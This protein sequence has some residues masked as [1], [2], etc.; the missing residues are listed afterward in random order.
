MKGETMRMK[1]YLAAITVLVAILITTT[2]QSSDQA[3]LALLYQKSGIGK[4]VA[5]YPTLVQ[6]GFDQTSANNPSS[7]NLPDWAL[8]AI[9]R[10]I[11]H[12]YDPEQI[13]KIMLQHLGEKLSAKDLTRV[14]RWLDSP[15]GRK[16]TELEEEASTIEALTEMQRFAGQLQDSP[17]SGKRL[18]TITS[19]DSALMATTAAVDVSINTQIAIAAVI[20]ASLPTEQ[21][22]PFDELVSLAQQ[23]RPDLEEVLHNRVITSYLYV[24]RDMPL[25]DLKNYIGFARTKAGMNYHSAVIEG[26]NDAFL[27]ATFSMGEAIK[28][29]LQ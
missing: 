9:R 11:K 19:L 22:T 1:L 17:P 28:A 25:S 5:E 4:K 23:N 29:E 26:L 10:N 8:R 27:R 20:V 14:I 6:M 15:I 24:Y 21:Q 18:D 2:A 3:E 13:K 16:C 7:A 12:A